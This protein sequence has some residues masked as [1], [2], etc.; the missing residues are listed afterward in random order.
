MSYESVAELSLDR[1]G[2]LLISDQHIQALV[3]QEAQEIEIAQERSIASNASFV[4]PSFGICDIYDPDQKEVVWLEDGVCVSQQKKNR[5]KI[6]KG[7]RER[8]TTDM[9]LLQRPT[10]GFECI[11]AAGKVSLTELCSSKLKQYYTGENI[12]IVALSDGSRTIKNR[13]QALFGS[14]YIHI[15]DW[16][17]LQKKVKELMCMIAPN[18]ETKIAYVS[19]LN[20]LFWTGKVT[21]AL[22]KL[23]N[24]TV[25]NQA[26]HL[27]LI[28][29]IEKNKDYIINYESR[30]AAKKTIGSGRM[31]KKGDK[32]VAK[33]QKEKAMSW[34][35][36]GSNAMAV[37]TAKYDNLTTEN[38]H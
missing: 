14:N 36:K 31:E 5:D 34:S 9:V 24:Y 38:L 21:D 18:K 26:K 12:N 32:I 29:Y 15:L 17:H 23:R 4:S 30:K 1:C 11:V 7:G 10:T 37:L 8:T 6:A 33:R 25:K 28:G 3:L 27:E 22:Q 13:C 16:Y 19:E 20:H 35:A 2:G